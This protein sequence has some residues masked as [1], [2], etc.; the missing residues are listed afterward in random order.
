M[1]T[2]KLALTLVITAL[3]AACD[4]TSSD[5]LTLDS[6]KAIEPTITLDKQNSA[7]S[8]LVSNTEPHIQQD[9]NTIDWAPLITK[10][11]AKQAHEPF[12]LP[13]ENV[14]KIRNFFSKNQNKKQIKNKQFDET[15]YGFF[16]VIQYDDGT[17]LD[18]SLDKVNNKYF[19][20][21]SNLRG[22][23]QPLEPFNNIHK[24]AVYKMLDISGADNPE[25]F[26]QEL[27]SSP[28]ITKYKGCTVQ[29][30]QS[31]YAMVDLT[32]CEFDNRTD[33]S[34]YKSKP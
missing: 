27:I 5:S 33:L 11:P 20:K 8:V 29:Q 30:K 18:Y 13:E 3:F 9:I 7:E 14:K 19:V 16:V 32:S 25:V 22:N 6:G 1:K 31:K 15:A 28:K 2:I 21:V 26:F 10:T 24:D 12:F 17:I 23:Y 4:A 34:L